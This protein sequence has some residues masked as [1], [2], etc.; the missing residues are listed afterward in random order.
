MSVTSS[1][2]WGHPRLASARHRLRE[3][4]NSNVDQQL[5]RVEQARRALKRGEV[6]VLFL[7]D[8]TCL[9]GAPRDEDTTMMPGLISRELGGARVL[10]ISGPGYSAPLRSEILRFLGT[11]DQRPQALVASVCV[12]TSVA[13]HV[14][15]HPVYSY[16]RSREALARIPSADRRVSYVRRSPRPDEEAYATFGAL[17]VRTR[18]TGETTIGYFRSRLMGNGPLPW[19][20]DLERLLFDYFHGEVV[21]A[22]NP[23]LEASR[24]FGRQVR[25]YGVPTVAYVPPVPIHQGERHYPGEFADLTLANRRVLER[26]LADSAGPDWR[27]V[28]ED[29]E[30]DDFVDHRD[31]VEHFAFSGRLK[32]ARAVAGSLAG[33]V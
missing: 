22:D 17:P 21:T 23:R 14:T 5:K 4:R 7:G 12:R 2:L 26:A 15:E 20:G 25:E 3:L 18:W 11:L 32:I 28:H 1:G 16:V 24:A 29:L 27:L 10:D 19:P 13:V 9:F 6:D 8:S 31:G 30:D 33:V